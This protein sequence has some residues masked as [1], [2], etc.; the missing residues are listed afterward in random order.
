MFTNTPKPAD[1]LSAA[2]LELAKA[3]DGLITDQ[4][5]A[6]ARALALVLDLL[7]QRGAK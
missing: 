4:V 1:R 2:R 5:A 6:V 7:E 3:K